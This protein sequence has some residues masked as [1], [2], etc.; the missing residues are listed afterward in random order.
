MGY[1]PPTANHVVGDHN[2]T[3]VQIGTVHGAVTVRGHLSVPDG[4]ISTDPPLDRLTGPL[5][6]RDD[7]LDVL[8]DAVSA[9]DGSVVVLHGTGGSGKTAVALGLAARVRDHHRGARVWWV[10]ATTDHSLSAGCREIALD[11]G[12]P[13]DQV[14]AAWT[15]A[16]SP[17]AVLAAALAR[18][19]H[20]W[21][22][23][24]DNA[25]DARTSAPWLPALRGS[26][27]A[28]VV[29]TR[30]GAADTWPSGARL[31]PVGPLAEEHAADVLCGLAPDAGG[32]PAARRLAR[33]LGRLPLALHL[34][35][36]YLR[37]AAHHPP[38]PGVA[39][40]VDFDHY[41]RVF[42]TRF[43]HV[44]QLH[45][46][47]GALEDRTL[48]ARTWELTLDLLADLGLPRTRPLLR[49]LAC[50]APAPLPYTAVDADV[51]AASPRFPG[52]TGPEIVRSLTALTDF[53][54][55]DDVVFHD[56]RA[57]A[58]RI[59]CLLLHPVIREA[60][61]HQP[62]LRAAE[63]EYLALCIAVLDGATTHL[64]VTD[65]EQ[66]SRWA[67]LAP[68]CDHVVDRVDDE[69]L[70]RQWELLASKLTRTTAVLAHLTGAHARAEA[71]FARALDTR[72]RHLG[73]HHPDVLTVRRDLAWLAHTR[74]GRPP[75]EYP[76]LVR[77]CATLLGAHHPLTLTCRFDLA[78][79]T[80]QTG[81]GDAATA[82]RD[83]VHAE[84]RAL[85]R[86]DV[87]GLAAQLE[88]VTALWRRA[89]AG[90]DPDP[91]AAEFRRLHEMI[92]DIAR[93]PEAHRGLPVPIEV[94]RRTA[95]ELDA[96][97]ARR[98]ASRA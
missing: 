40:P 67:A 45:Q 8:A 80:A 96:G 47:R 38:V 74:D 29:T 44:D 64:T 16:R 14:V 87:S 77:D 24:L 90:D 63:Q 31:L 7:L 12:A 83:V 6:G 48:L 75:A 56:P 26:T 1:S 21:L 93:D 4:L 34:A 51:L 3:V 50:F 20:R 25:D 84:H 43:P 13:V 27:G 11:A 39:L 81:A 92:D 57:S 35:G 30:D 36:R 78:W 66:L 72:R 95:R 37:A 61:R 79:I 65:P 68:H 86:H 76:A 10:D 52:I 18:T 53:G 59:R 46:L 88:L 22:V 5:H 98:R 89:L 71:L 32:R 17:V 54:L 70:P 42:R 97:F 58:S 69:A 73:D 85:G 2:D 62:D 23:V 49:W 55:L 82:L 9:Q 60:T 33:A 15:G 28:I 19:P 94:L 41:R 91:V